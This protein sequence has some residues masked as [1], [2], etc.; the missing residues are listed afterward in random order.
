[1][2]FNPQSIAVVGASRNPSKA[3][4][5]ILENILKTFDRKLIYPI[6]PSADTILDVKCY[7]SLLDVQS[8]IDLV[9]FFVPP[10]FIPK[11]LIECSQKNVRGVIIQ[12]AG[13]KEVG[14][15]GEKIQ[16]EIRKLGEQFNIRIWGGN[17]MATITDTLITTFLPILEGEQSKFGDV[18]IVGQS[19][20]FSGAIYNLFVT[21]R[22]IGIKMASSI[23]NRIDISE[24]D[25]VEY[26]LHDS[27]TKVI[28]VY[29]EGFKDPRKFL[30]IT[31]RS[32]KPIVCLIGGKSK[33]GKK[34][35]L[36]HTASTAS[37]SA[38][39][40][41]GILKQGNCISVDDFGEMFDLLE[42]FSKLPVIK[43]NRITIA[44][45]TGAGG[46]VGSDIADKNGFILPE[47]SEVTMK[48]LQ[49][50]YPPWMPPNNP[51]DLWPAIEI[52]NANEAITNSL[53]VVFKN[54]EVDAAIVMM[55]ALHLKQSK[56]FSPS[57]LL[58]LMK[59]YNKPILLW[60]VGLNDMKQQWK[61]EYRKES[62]MVLE[63][64]QSCFNVFKK[65]LEFYKKNH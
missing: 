20:Y 40:L 17:S 43:G 33:T 35:A 8:D 26:Y 9:I 23:G 58:E 15:E 13:L 54:D 11:L 14:G 42:G 48:D 62:G 2:F 60:I 28:G 27:D 7:K 5:M 45:I 57:I 3:G 59:K 63:D 49:N 32:K 61:T 16:E 25:L 10:K 47:F 44:T 34:A 64:I 53:D 52:A 22:N 36:S 65:M 41:E 6:N 24:N 30:S 38:E 56:S 29:L 37:G 19:G 12:S 31:R 55:A 21:E 39:V 50:V 51:L 1:M 46:V 18:S 4:Y